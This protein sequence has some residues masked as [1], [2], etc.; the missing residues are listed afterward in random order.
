[1]LESRPRW[2]DAGSSSLVSTVKLTT[3]EP[4]GF[5]DACSNCSS[6]QPA[7]SS[8]YTDV[9]AAAEVLTEFIIDDVFQEIDTADV[10]IFDLRN[11]ER[12]SAVR[13]GCAIGSRRPYSSSRPGVPEMP[14]A[15]GETN[16]DSDND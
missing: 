1:M 15:R 7:W 4:S 9:G 10:S 6:N 3:G 13:V 16:G 8:R 2:F 11:P 5:I 12:N 14:N